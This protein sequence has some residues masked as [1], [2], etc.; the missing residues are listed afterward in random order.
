MQPLVKVLVIV[1]IIVGIIIIGSV[2]F[3][4][5]AAN[6]VITGMEGYIEDRA[7]PAPAAGSYEEALRDLPG[8]SC[9]EAAEAV[10]KFPG[11]KN[12]Q[13]YMVVGSMCSLK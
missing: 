8:M 5:Y 1:V 13:A 2:A 7:G 6:Q 12:T 9:S 3:S 4:F 11:L 10:E